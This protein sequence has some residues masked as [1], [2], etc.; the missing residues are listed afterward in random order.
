MPGLPLLAVFLV[1]GLARLAPAYKK[2]VML[3]LSVGSLTLTLAVL[4]YLHALYAPPTVFAASNVVGADFGNTIRV[5]NYHVEPTRAAP[6]D[7]IVVQ[8]DWQSLKTTREDYWLMLQLTDGT[9]AIAQKDGVPSAGRLTTDWWQTGQVLNSRHTLVVPQ[10]AA[11][12]TYTL[13][14]GLH[15]F[16]RWEWLPV[17]GNDSLMLGKIVIAAEE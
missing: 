8:F 11:P 7:A 17:R 4:F 3:A 9:E 2:G 14:V 12:G 5:V 13:R 10:D 1:A 15:P 6:G 16:G